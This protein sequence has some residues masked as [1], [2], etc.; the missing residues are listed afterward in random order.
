MSKVQSERI[1]IPSPE[2]GS[3]V[4]SSSKLDIVIKDPLKWLEYPSERIS[5]PSLLS[6]NCT[7]PASD[8]KKHLGGQQHPQICPPSF[9]EPAS[10]ANGPS[11]NPWQRP[12]FPLS[13][14]F[15]ASRDDVIS[16]INVSDPVVTPSLTRSDP[17]PAPSL[18]RGSPSPT[19]S[20]SIPEMTWTQNYWQD[21]HRDHASRVAKETKGDSDF[22]CKQSFQ[23]VDGRKRRMNTFIGAP[24]RSVGFNRTLHSHSAYACQ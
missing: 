18:S 22:V 3:R 23:W 16:R 11:H 17:S 7:F 10:F 13:P 21:F 8:G 9:L 6:N 1:G 15:R 4:P 5:S 20:A 19:H 2:A 24:P 14:L 12:G